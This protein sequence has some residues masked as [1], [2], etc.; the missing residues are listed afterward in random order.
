MASIFMLFWL[1][2]FNKTTNKMRK[3]KCAYIFAKK[4]K[5]VNKKE[6]KQLLKASK[7]SANKKFQQ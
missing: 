3:E 7:S 5:M 4:N 1:N 6:S 2:P